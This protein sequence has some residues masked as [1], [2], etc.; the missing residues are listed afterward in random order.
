MRYVEAQEEH[1]ENMF[2]L[3]E[4]PFPLFLHLKRQFDLVIKIHSG[5]DKA[6]IVLN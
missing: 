2:T 5:E 6:F 3:T 1:L 4:W